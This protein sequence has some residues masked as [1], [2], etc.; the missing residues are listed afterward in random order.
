MP[1]N[2][3]FFKIISLDL[4][5]AFD[6]VDHRVLFAVLENKFGLNFNV[7]QWIKSYLCN[8]KMCTKVESAKSSE[9]TFNFSVPQGSCLGPV[10]FNMYSSTIIDV[11]SP[12]QDLG[13]YADDHILRDLS[14]I[15]I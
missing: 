2:L 15:H 5:A 6:T 13:G 12:E 7:L 14:L 9:R 3:T 4:S 10:L 8:R 11:I 1:T